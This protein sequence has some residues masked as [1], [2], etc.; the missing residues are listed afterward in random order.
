MMLNEYQTL[1]NLVI[2]FNENIEIIIIK[3]IV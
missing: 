1:N 3:M 2:A